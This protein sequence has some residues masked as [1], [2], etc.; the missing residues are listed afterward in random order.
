MTFFNAKIL[1]KKTFVN[2]L[3]TKEKMLAYRETIR[4]KPFKK[5]KSFESFLITITIL[6]NDDRMIFKFCGDENIIKGV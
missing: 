1:T 5:E 4:I 6:S 3:K 2:I